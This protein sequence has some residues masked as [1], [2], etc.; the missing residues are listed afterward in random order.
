MSMA[1]D[2]DE[3]I[4]LEYQENLLTPKQTAAQEANLNMSYAGWSVDIANIDELPN[5]QF[6]IARRKG[7]GG[8][9]SSILLGVNPYTTLEELIDQKSRDTLTEEEKA[10]GDK[11]AVRKGRDLEPLIISKFQKFFGLH[12]V[13]PKDMYRCDKFPYLTMNF[14]GITGVAGAYIPVEI[15][16]VTARGERHYNPRNAIFIE[17]QGTFEYPEDITQ[18]NLSIQSK[19]A[20]Y[21][22]PT[23]YYTQ[24]Q[25]EIAASGASYGYL[26]TLYD[27]DWTMHTYFV[28]R[29]QTTIN[30]IITQ[31]FKAWQK[32]VEKNPARK[33]D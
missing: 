14:D 4:K 15:K 20:H 26:N 22:I 13:K 11:V 31:G 9:D 3:D 5:D 24:L 8:S 28:H 16:V 1:Y 33:L 7:F 32:V 21:G 17:G 6:A 30:A 18:R 29:D 2:T 25:Q 12:T 27:K 10:I 23:Y 19:A